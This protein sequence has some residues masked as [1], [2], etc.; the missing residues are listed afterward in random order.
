MNIQTKI[1]P[2]SS[3]E[4]IAS[5]GNIVENTRILIT[6]LSENRW[7]AYEL[8][9]L[10]PK[11]P[12]YNTA[13]IIGDELAKKLYDALNGLKIYHGT[14]VLDSD[15]KEWFVPGTLAD[16]EVQRAMSDEKLLGL[17]AV[18]GQ[19]RRR[20]E[21]SL[22]DLIFEILSEKGSLEQRRIV[23]EV[24][25]HIGYQN[26]YPDHIA[27]RKAINGTLRNNSAKGKSKCQLFERHD[28]GSRLSKWG[29]KVEATPPPIRVKPQV[30]ALTT[31]M[32]SGSRKKVWS[33]PE[34]A[35]IVLQPDSGYRVAPGATLETVQG[36]IQQHLTGKN[37]I[38]FKKNHKNER[39]GW[40]LARQ[41]SKITLKDRLETLD[42][43][44]E[45]ISVGEVL[46]TLIVKHPR[47]TWNELE[48]L[49]NPPGA[50]SISRLTGASRET[51]EAAKI[52]LTILHDS[53]VSRMR[54][55]HNDPELVSRRLEG[56]AR[57]SHDSKADR[58]DAL[59]DQG[60]DIIS[61]SRAGW[62]QI[63]SVVTPES[64]AMSEERDVVITAALD[65]LSPLE[66]QVIELSFFGD[67]LSHEGLPK[68]YTSIL[69]SALDKLATNRQLQ[70]I[71]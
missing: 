6:I 9:L 23:F 25:S 68:R 2:R 28:D 59:H 56:V 13:G 62:L 40:Q 34:L 66:R 33:I 52:R 29:V 5:M 67:S 19:M 43:L 57:R 4:V 39:R 31:I 36:S 61:T 14:A 38:W 11:N 45:G 48:R 60:I 30:L 18:S 12:N 44:A 20:G 47:I 69:K 53:L 42:L 41:R 37:K 8:S 46:E 1:T 16:P 32:S 15:K 26:T 55:I 7:T 64:I 17:I 10:I 70:E 51:I 50:Y 21:R 27:L 49:Y 65:S 24:K 63:G 22:R 3:D 71:A 35:S 58:I 54:N